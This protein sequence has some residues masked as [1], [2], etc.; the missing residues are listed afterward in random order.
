MGRKKIKI[1]RI[2]DDRNRQV[3]TGISITDVKTGHFQQE[4]E[5]THK[6]S[7]GVVGPLRI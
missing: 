4:K 1:E 2:E 5:R 3:G 7:Y 6:E